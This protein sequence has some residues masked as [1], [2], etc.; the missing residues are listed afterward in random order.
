M[1]RL[2]IYLIVVG[3]IGAGA[4]WLASNPGEIVITWFGYRTVTSAFA[5]VGVLALVLA[6]AAVLWGGV[7]GI[8]SAPGRVLGAMRERRERRGREALRH[9][10]FAVG[11]GDAQLAARYASE[12]RQALEHEPLTKLLRAQAAQIS[13][14]HATAKRIFETMLDSDETRLMGL[15]G[16]FLEAQRENRPEDA[17]RFALRAI[18]TRP[19]LPWAS[20]AV[21]DL[22]CRK[23]DWGGALKTLAAMR[24]N[25]LIDRKTAD[26]RRA[27]LLSAQ[28]Q[29]VE[30][31]DQDA[32]GRLAQEAHG[33][34]PD[35]VPAA[36]I[37]GRVLAA[38]GHASRAAKLLARTWELSPHPDIAL[39]YAYVR[40]GDS[41]RDRLNRV[42]A[43]TRHRPEH[44]ESR[45][46][47]AAAAVDAHAWDEARAALEP[48]LTARPPRRVC[49]LMARIEAG[50]TRN[51]GRV[52]EWLAKAVRAPRDPAWVADGVVS[53]RWA[54]I[55]PVTGR[56]DAF[57]WRIPMERVAPG[58]HDA[59]P[60]EIAELEQLEARTDTVTVEAQ[61]QTQSEAQEPAARSGERPAD[62]QTPGAQSRS[63]GHTDTQASPVRSTTAPDDR[64]AVFALRAP[65]DPGPDGAEGEDVDGSARQVR[66][67]AKS[68]H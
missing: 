37:A 63:A 6:I 24:Q 2:L 13:G 54:P 39:T 57:D 68:N 47:L 7:R 66:A 59:L 8:F 60:L 20:E 50:E 12:A 4:A 28:A 10:I 55:S 23:G 42:R 21:F 45:V 14:D 49:T 38:Q 58:A 33:L 35:L 40:P 64:A 36:E 29:A 15:H 43:L 27:V 26:R 51:A 19:A 48:L 22:Q 25:K 41:P 16:L 46:A 52:R 62:E 53:D 1:L 5:A 32:A 44:V 11:A 17:E 18:E 61:P 34:A 3:A 65:D 31:T 67:P 56:L 30:L 9:G